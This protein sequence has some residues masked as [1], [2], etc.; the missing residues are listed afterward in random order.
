[1]NSW[2]SRQRTE[3]QRDR[4]TVRIRENVEKKIP[5]L[6]NTETEIHKD[7]ETKRQRDREAERQRDR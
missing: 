4:A 6:R 1:M 3:G 7:R 2:T 5:R